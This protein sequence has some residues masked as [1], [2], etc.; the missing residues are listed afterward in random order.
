[1]KH[2]IR[3]VFSLVAVF[4]LATVCQRPRSPPV[5]QRQSPERGQRQAVAGASVIAIHLPSG[6]TYETTTRADGRFIII[7]MRVGGPYSVTVAY[8]GT[9][10][11]AFAPETQDNIEINLGVA[12]DLDVR[13]ASNIAVT[14]T[15][16]VTAQVR[17]G[18]QLGPHRRGDLGQPR[19]AGLAADRAR[20]ASATSRAS[21]RRPRAPTRSAAP[22]AA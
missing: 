21:R 18:V 12:T 16:T 14:E 6:T 10:A 13:R 7:N 4:A 11:A 9:G 3:F 2:L 1:M 20:P 22:T 19:D 8:T 5:P 17:H 15:V